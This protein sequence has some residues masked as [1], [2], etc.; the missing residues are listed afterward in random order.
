MPQSDEASLNSARA[1]LIEALIRTGQADREAFRTVYTMTSAKLFGICLRICVDRQ[2]AEDV[3]HDVYI[4]IWNRAGGYQPG[5]ASPISWLA[6][7]ARN[8]AIDWRRRQGRTRAAPV[9]EADAIPDGKPRQD[10]VLV[11]DEATARLHHCLEG[12]EIRQRGAIRS[13][14]F[15][16]LTYAE[17]AERQAVPLGTMKSWVRRGLQA[18][19]GCLDADA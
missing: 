2:G 4:T 12:I 10:D 11:A 13:A 14:F 3:L 5:R 18:L 19:R 7:I 16:G 17:L 6:T 8:R 15:G 1:A 9:D